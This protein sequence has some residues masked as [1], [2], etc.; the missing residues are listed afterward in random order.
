[1][2][3]VVED[4]DIE[5]LLQLRL[6]AE[7][8]RAL[9]IFKVYSAEGD[10]D[11][12]HDRDDLVGIP[13]G[14]FDVDRV[15]V[16]EPFEEDALALHHGFR[17]QCAQIAETKDGRAVRN[18]RDQIALGRVVVCGVGIRGDRPD[19]HSHPGG[20][21]EAQVPLRRHWLGRRDRN[22]SRRRILMEVE[23]FL[24]REARLLVRHRD[25]RPGVSLG[26]AYS[27]LGPQ[28]L[29]ASKTLKQTTPTDGGLI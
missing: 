8:F 10:S 22:L 9:D 6:N 21:G 17:S 12:L 7:A 26:Q 28:R 3:I 13:G 23:S 19:G 27:G 11:I 18:D 29:K 14:D 4:W 20:I 2:L 15:D 24:V 25:F 16:S 5:Q 1:M